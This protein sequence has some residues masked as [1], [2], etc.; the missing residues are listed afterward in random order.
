MGS[1]TMQ[2]IM[3]AV[4]SPAL[5]EEHICYCLSENHLSPT[6]TKLLYLLQ[7]RSEVY[8]RVKEL[9]LKSDLCLWLTNR[10]LIVTGNF[11]I[12]KFS[13]K[14]Q[15]QL[16]LLSLNN[17]YSLSY[18]KLDNLEY[19]SKDLF[20][21]QQLSV[22]VLTQTCKK[23]NCVNKRYNLWILFI[24]ILKETYCS[25]GNFYIC[26][27]NMLLFSSSIDNWGIYS[28]KKDFRLT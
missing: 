6:P 22:K 1:D 16:S 25:T 28:S 8:K 18:F 17:R 20:H 27:T 11:S 19:L 15:Y 9:K 4:F 3:E 23:C 2:H 7:L 12:T 13:G 14:T 24:L 21:K 10:N 5:Q 26:E